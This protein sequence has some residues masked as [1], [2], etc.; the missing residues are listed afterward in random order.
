MDI[1][2]EHHYAIQSPSTDPS[3]DCPQVQLR[4]HSQTQA[5]CSGAR[6][7]EQ[8]KMHLSLQSDAEPDEGKSEPYMRETLKTDPNQSTLEMGNVGHSQL[9]QQNYLDQQDR[10]KAYNKMLHQA[11]K[12]AARYEEAVQRL[13]EKITACQDPLKLQGL[14]EQRD[15]VEVKIGKIHQETI[16]IQQMITTQKKGMGLPCTNTMSPV[17]NP[18]QFRNEKMSEPEIEENLLGNCASVSPEI[19]PLKRRKKSEK[20]ESEE[21]E[22]EKELRKADNQVQENQENPELQ[23]PQLQHLQTQKALGEF[24]APCRYTFSPT[25]RKEIKELFRGHSAGEFIDTGTESE[26]EGVQGMQGIVVEEHAEHTKDNKR[27][28]VGDRVEGQVEGQEGQKGLEE[29][30]IGKTHK[31]IGQQAQG[32]S[33]KQSQPLIL[34]PPP[35]SPL[36]SCPTSP[37]RP[38]R[39]QRVAREVKILKDWEEVKMSP[40]ATGLAV[41]NP[42]RINKIDLPKFWGFLLAHMGLPDAPTMK[43]DKRS[44]DYVID[45]LNGFKPVLEKFMKKRGP[46]EPEFLDKLRILPYHAKLNNFNNKH[47]QCS[48]R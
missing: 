13:E 36:G 5:Q 2:K 31:L 28:N 16:Q 20:E 10:L 48:T 25:T 37:I 32:Q 15:G 45:L 14:I 19:R 21:K 35:P 34:N 17:L 39:E 11:Y 26:E 9:V 23:N 33:G 44:K 12:A 8:T 30:R 29:D 42:D 47:D 4:A 40:M 38:H 22:R 46:K 3:R 43:L 27:E 1:R 18:E 41:L 24:V 7:V 6:V